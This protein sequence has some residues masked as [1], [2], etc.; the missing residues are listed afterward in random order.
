MTMLLTAMGTLL[1]RE[2]FVGAAV[3]DPSNGNGEEPYR[4]SIAD[5]TEDDDTA[6]AT[7]CCVGNHQF[8]NERVAQ[9]TD[10]NLLYLT[11]KKV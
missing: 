6:E 7:L 8:S 5:G 10:A 11:L 1:R 4:S 3:S 2:T 9:V